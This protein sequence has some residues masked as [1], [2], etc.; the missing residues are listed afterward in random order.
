MF[1]LVSIIFDNNTYYAKATI[2]FGIGVKEF[3]PDYT[4][5]VFNIFP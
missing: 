4:S 1:Y 2:T 3:L 5:W